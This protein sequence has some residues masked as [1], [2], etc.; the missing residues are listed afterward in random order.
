MEASLKAR[1]FATH[2]LVIEQNRKVLEKT[3]QKCRNDIS[4]DEVGKKKIKKEIVKEEK[5]QRQVKRENY[6]SKYTDKK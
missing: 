2:P 3:K 5:Q 4:N 6:I 1:T